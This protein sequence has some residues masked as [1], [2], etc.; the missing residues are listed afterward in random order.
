MAMGVV[1]P[2]PPP[3]FTRLTG[4]ALWREVLNRYELEQ[5]EL[6][7]LREIVRCVDD[8]DRLANVAGRQGA[9]SAGGDV[10]PAVSE[11][12][13][14]RMTLATLISALKLPTENEDDQAHLRRPQRYP[15][16]RRVDPPPSQR[17]PRAVAGRENAAKTPQGPRAVVGRI[18]VPPPARQ[19]RVT[20]NRPA[21]SN[22]ISVAELMKRVQNERSPAAGGSRGST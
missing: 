1:P 5:H 12:R 20:A 7:L 11:A 13:Q 2:G 21:A 19:R 10:H 6:L 3:K 4:E 22:Q 9:I 18:D 8:L 15:V 14:M 16:V 17:E